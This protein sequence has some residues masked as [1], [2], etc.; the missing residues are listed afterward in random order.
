MQD[1]TYSIFVS[2]AAVDEEIAYS[3]KQYIEQIFPEQRVFVSSDPEDLKPGDEWVIKILKAL[4][5]A[6]CVLALTTERGLGRKWVWFELG[7]TWFSEVK[8]IPCCIGKIRKGNLPAPFSGRMA[9]NIDEPRDAA[10]LFASLQELF[11]APSKALDY[12]KFVQTMIRLDVRA[13]EKSKILEDAYSEEIMS[14]IERTMKSLSPSQRETIKQF[15]K[16][17]ELSTAGAKLRVKETGVNM[18]RWTVPSALIEQ[19]GWLVSNAGNTP[20][21][22]MQQNVYSINATVRPYLRAYFQRQK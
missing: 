9:I 7:R 3:I 22:D 20:Y 21:D 10:A 15:A 19:T 18:D 16:Y 17:G 14:D 13:E 4:E 6:K 5:T 11:G 12:D 2:H 1:Q 8:L